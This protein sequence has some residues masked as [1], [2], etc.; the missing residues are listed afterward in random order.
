MKPVFFEKTQA[1]EEEPCLS[2]KLLLRVTIVPDPEYS[3]RAFRPICLHF[4]Y[5]ALSAGKLPGIII[6]CPALPAFLP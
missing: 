2:G 3:D 4:E 1:D 6:I 5:I